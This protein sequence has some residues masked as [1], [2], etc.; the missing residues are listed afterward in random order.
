V[1]LA[2]RSIHLSAAQQRKLRQLA[3]AN[4][5]SEAEI[6]RRAVDRLPDSG[7]DTCKVASGLE[8]AIIARLASAGALAPPP[9]GD[10]APADPVELEALEREHQAWLVTQTEPLG[11]SE[12]VLAERE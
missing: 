1:A 9:D 4:N 8:E 6:V 11:L 2:R 10:D 12:A 3:A 7:S 5:C